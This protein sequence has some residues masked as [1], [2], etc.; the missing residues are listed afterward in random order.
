VAYWGEGG[1]GLR[2]LVEEL[3]LP[4]LAHDLARGLVPEDMELAFPWPVASIAARH[5]DVVLVAGTRMDF[6][7]SYA[8][9]PHFRDAARFIQVDIDG[10]EIGRNR[11]VESPVVGDCG[12][13]LEALAVELA[14][15]EYQPRDPAWAAAALRARM[16][17][18]PIFVSGGANC[19][20]WFKSVVRVRESPGWLDYDPFGSMGVGLPL[21]IRA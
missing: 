10:A 17:A 20:N 9:P 7:I 4:V 2:R 1:A 16:P 15:R 21:A 8:A 13:A 12:P 6:R 14:R 5:A 18:N 3:R 11:Y 19:A